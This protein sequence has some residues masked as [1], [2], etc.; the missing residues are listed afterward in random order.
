MTNILAKWTDPECPTAS[1]VAYVGDLSIEICIEVYKGGEGIFIPINAL[2]KFMHE[3][4]SSL[5]D[6]GVNP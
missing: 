4:E 5:D 6:M 2:R 3:L 1:L